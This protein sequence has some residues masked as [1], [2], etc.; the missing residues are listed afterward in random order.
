MGD[1]GYIVGYM[2]VF[3]FLL[4][5]IIGYWVGRRERKHESK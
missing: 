4:G 2:V 5:A 1:L 3:A